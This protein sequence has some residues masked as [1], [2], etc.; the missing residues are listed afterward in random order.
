MTPPC[1]SQMRPPEPES[2]KLYW[3][4]V[5][6]LSQQSLPLEKYTEQDLYP[7][8]IRAILHSAQIGGWFDWR[9]GHAAW[10]PSWLVRCTGKTRQ[11]RACHA[12]ALLQPMPSMVVRSRLQTASLPPRRR[13]RRKLLAKRTSGR[14][15][16]T[17]RP[18]ALRTRCRT[19]NSIGRCFNLSRHPWHHC[20]RQSSRGL[21]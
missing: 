10:L 2:D 16:A 15:G 14:A 19:S 3:Q 6:A 5:G 4:V 17:S 11:R 21:Y 1:G 20:R 13:I 8:I 9:F 12:S 7:W 18:Q